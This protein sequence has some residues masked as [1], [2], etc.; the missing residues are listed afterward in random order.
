MDLNERQ[1][2][3]LNG[4]FVVV[5]EAAPVLADADLAAIVT[6]C[7][8]KLLLANERLT[9]HVLEELYHTMACR[10]AIKAHDRTAAPTLRQLVELLRADGDADHCPHGRPVSIRM[11]RHEIEKKFGRLG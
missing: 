2:E 6:E 7:A 11:S 10:S 1:L 4:G 5:R 9:P 3:A 8:Q